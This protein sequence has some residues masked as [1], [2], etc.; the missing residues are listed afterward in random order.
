MHASP[1]KKVDRQRQRGKVERRNCG[2]EDDLFC[3][4]KVDIHVRQLNGMIWF[5]FHDTA[6]TITTPQLGFGLNNAIDPDARGDVYT[7]V[8]LK[9]HRR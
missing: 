4:F 9:T 7:Y 5:S 3:F 2:P 8:N 1:K 6:H